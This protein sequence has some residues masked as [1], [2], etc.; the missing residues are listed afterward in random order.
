MVDEEGSERITKGTCFV[1]MGSGPKFFSVIEN[2]A[3][4]KGKSVVVSWHLL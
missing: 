3:I 1:M 2:L 4:K